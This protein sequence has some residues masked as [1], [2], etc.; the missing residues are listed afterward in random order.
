MPLNWSQV[1]AGLDPQRF[2]MRTAPAV[3]GK[4]HPW[5]EYCDGERPLK[6]AIEKLVKVR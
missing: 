1:K 3:L 4:S 6:Q 5:E 2:T